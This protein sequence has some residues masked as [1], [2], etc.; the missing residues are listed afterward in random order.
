MTAEHLDQN[1]VRTLTAELAHLR[2]REQ[3]ANVQ[4]RNAQMTHA[5]QVAGL[6]DQLRTMEQRAE[7]AA[8][9]LRCAAGAPTTS[10]ASQAQIIKDHVAAE[11]RRAQAIGASAPRMTVNVALGPDY[12]YG[13]QHHKDIR[14]MEQIA[15]RN[16]SVAARDVI[17]RSA[18]NLLLGYKDVV[19]VSRSSQGG[20]IDDT[21]VRV[22]RSWHPRSL[23]SLA[24]VVADQ[25]FTQQDIDDALS[26]FRLTARLW[27]LSI[28]DQRAT[29]IYA[30][31]LEAAGLHEELISVFRETNFEERFPVQVA[32]LEHNHEMRS[33]QNAQHALRHLNRQ[34]SAA[35]IA[36]ITV[37]AGG[38]DLLERLEVEAPSVTNGPL[39]TIMM[40]TYNGSAHILTAI[41]SV[42][43]QTWANLELIVVDDHSDD[44]EWEY[45]KSVAPADERLTLVRLESNQGAYRAR[46]RAF[47]M[48]KGEFVAVHDDDDWS[49]PQKVETQVKALIADP[50]MV[51]NMSY[52]ARVDEDGRFVRI[53]DNPEFNQRNY[54]SLM[55]RADDVRRLGMWDDLNRAADAEFHDRIFAATGKRVASIETP[56][57]SFMRSRQGSLTSGEIRK[58]ALD[59]GRQTYGLLYQNWHLQLKSSIVPNEEVSVDFSSSERPFPVPQ[60]FLS[61][62]RRPRYEPFDVVYCTDFRFPGGNS[63]LTNAEIRAAH[64][65]GLRVAVLQLSSPVLRAPRP[66]NAAVARTVSELRIPV[67]AMEDTV[68]TR[69]LLVRNPSVLEYADN[70]QPNV[71][72][73]R[74]LIVANTAPMGING[75]EA[76]YDLERCRLNAQR[77]F[78]APV[79]ISPESP[80]TRSLL[81][82]LAPEVA[83]ADFDW[84]GFVFDRDIAHEPKHPARRQPVLGRHSRDHRLK[85]PDSKEEISATYIGGDR[86]ET[87]ILGGAG[88]IKSL[89]D[90]SVAGVQVHPFG[91]VEP[92]AFVSEVDFW[93]YMHSS[94]LIESFGMAALEAMASGC[95]VILPAYMEP[96]FG[97]A[98]IYATPAEVAGIVSAS[99]ADDASFQRQSELALAFVREHFSATAYIRRLRA[100]M[101]AAEESFAQAGVV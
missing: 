12:F 95:V 55:I 3:S 4:L 39:V 85:W 30:E 87:R 15:M 70:L 5:A 86:Y 74:T 73:Q 1:E 14:V 40:P 8:A 33:D 79:T 41:K 84:P 51:A 9:A 52:M 38:A 62:Q 50:G 29:L 88:S 21:R 77:A 42:L 23:L 11:I 64:E 89:I 7:K 2:E 6:T 35:N 83:L 94:Q 65:A 27:G 48:A 75:D 26:L 81:R 78:G 10:A 58:G 71:V 57:L 17:A 24:R 60:N 91:S 16:A 25:S 32:L 44:S 99:W 80:H 90:L 19:T 56:P 45:L 22:F 54:S 101:A 59:F 82:I 37:Q 96:L 34:L 36:P 68:E 72:S 43:A 49:H 20:L 76:C 53:N 28:F 47:S 61:G 31:L 98:A 67:L 63:S 92:R 97:S 18:T 66:F 93:V 100:V 46:L 69:V 13:G